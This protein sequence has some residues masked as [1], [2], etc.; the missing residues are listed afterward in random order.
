MKDMNLQ[1]YQLHLRITEAWL[2]AH[3]SLAV[4]VVICLLLLE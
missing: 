3:L 1:K 4:A 2:L